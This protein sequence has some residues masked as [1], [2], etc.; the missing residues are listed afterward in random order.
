MIY[1]LVRKT[2]GA[3]GGKVGNGGVV[4]YFEKKAYFTKRGL[5]KRTVL[6]ELY[7]HPVYVNGLEM[8]RSKEERDANSFAGDFF[9]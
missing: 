4:S 8:P 3:H 7:H 1:I 6:H 5:T 2:S 9:G